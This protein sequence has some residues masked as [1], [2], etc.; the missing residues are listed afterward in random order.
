MLRRPVFGLMHMPHIIKWLV[1]VFLFS[2]AEISI[3]V[4]G[5]FVVGCGGDRDSRAGCG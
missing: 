2:F 5:F 1:L 3:S 4:C